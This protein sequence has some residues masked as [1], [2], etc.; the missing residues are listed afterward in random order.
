MPR[1]MLSCT[2][3]LLQQTM[4][5]FWSWRTRPYL[6]QRAHKWPTVRTPRILVCS[7]PFLSLL[8][9]PRPPNLT[10]TRHVTQPML[11]LT[12]KDHRQQRRVL[13]KTLNGK[14]DHIPSVSRLGAIAL[15]VVW[16]ELN[17]STP[18]I[19]DPVYKLDHSGAKTPV[20]T[21]QGFMV[22]DSV[23]SLVPVHTLSCSPPGLTVW[24]PSARSPLGA[25]LPYRR[26]SYGISQVV[27]HRRPQGRIGATL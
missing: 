8:L 18:D 7:P 3:P 25:S 26:L 5:E 27:P 15:I 23:G 12:E 13:K 20:G 17:T 11:L 10:A 14:I 22:S 6:C 24:G 19:G 4:P 2:P 16:D 1:D 9:S 21:Y